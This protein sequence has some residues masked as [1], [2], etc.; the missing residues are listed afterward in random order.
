MESLVENPKPF[1]LFV[2]GSPG[3]GKTHLIKYVAFESLLKRR[4]NCVIVVSST[5]ELG[6]NYSWCDPDFLHTEFQEGLLENIIKTQ[7][8][9]K[10]EALLILDDE[11]GKSDFNSKIFK[12]LITIHRHINLSIIIAVQYLNSVLSPLLRNCVT[13]CAYFKQ[14]Q[15]RSIQGL[16]DSFGQKFDSVEAFRHHM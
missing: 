14:E 4:F 6:G 13:H 5:G 2:I 12:Q 15:K 1:V 7:K 9:T 8:E 3:S 10:Q 16:F 11:I